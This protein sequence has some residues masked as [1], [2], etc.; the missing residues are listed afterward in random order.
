MIKMNQHG[1]AG[2]VELLLIAVIIGGVSFTAWRGR[3]MGASTNQT[4]AQTESVLKSQENNQSQ[5][6]KI[7]QI[8][9][10]NQSY[11]DYECLEPPVFDDIKPII[12]WPLPDPCYPSILLKQKTSKTIYCLDQPDKLVEP[13]INDDKLQH[14][15]QQFADIEQ[16]AKTQ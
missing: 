12:I 13:P 10:D 16:E 7:Y 8:K 2:A 6:E 5:L 3:E 15:Q 14:I 4:V 11:R 9:S 1:L